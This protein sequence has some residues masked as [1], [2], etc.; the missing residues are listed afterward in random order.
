MCP[1]QFVILSA[2]KLTPYRHSTAVCSDL[3]VDAVMFARTKT[4][5]GPP[6]AD[7]F[8]PAHNR[9]ST[10]TKTASEQQLSCLQT[11]YITYYFFKTLIFHNPPYAGRLSVD[12]VYEGLNTYQST[13]H[14]G[15]VQ[16]CCSLLFVEDRKAIVLLLLLLLR[17]LSVNDVYQQIYHHHHCVAIVDRSVP[18]PR[19]SPRLCTCLPWRH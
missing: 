5:M 4:W 17:V 1:N 12:V 16:L 10:C 14:G 18:S 8:S 3:V 2:S 11:L 9:S 7:A 13:M 15:T 19:R 6:A